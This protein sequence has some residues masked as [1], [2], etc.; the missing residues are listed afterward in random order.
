MPCQ[1]SSALFI[2]C[3]KQL[4]I[5]PAWLD[6]L[7]FTFTPSSG[8]FCSAQSTYRQT[9]SWSLHLQTKINEDTCLW[10]L[11]KVYLP[12]NNVSLNVSFVSIY[13]LVFNH[14][15][16]ALAGPDFVCVT[17]IIFLVFYCSV[18]MNVLMDVLM[19]GTL[20]NQCSL[21]KVSPG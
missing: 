2:Y 3:P 20:E 13:F 15:L 4:L 14:F 17:L 11:P 19:P 5:S 7:L 6:L 21:W 1:N 10:Q 18:S 16:H 12:F 9:S 8:F